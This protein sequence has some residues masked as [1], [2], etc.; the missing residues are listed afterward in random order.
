MSDHQHSGG[1]PASFSNPFSA[2]EEVSALYLILCAGARELRT[3]CQEHEEEYN[4]ALPVP[5]RKIAEL[6]NLKIRERNLS[7]LDV[8]ANS[9]ASIGMLMGKLDYD[10]PDG[11]T[12]H[13][14]EG[15][16]SSRKNYVIAHEL[17]HHWM[18]KI[19]GEPLGPEHCSDTRLSVRYIEMLSDAFS[20][21]LLLPIKALFQEEKQ[22]IESH[23]Q[24]PVNLEEMLA[25]VAQTADV[26]YYYVLTGY[27]YIKAVICCARAS[28][29]KERF[30]ERLENYLNGPFS[31]LRSQV[32]E[33]RREIREIDPIFF[34]QT[35]GAEEEANG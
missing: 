31:S 16:S 25:K 2:F 8:T 20:A 6:E 1:T 30:E 24:R 9:A 19:L 18:K 3:R 22:Y 28:A 7:I 12:I 35:E 13:L 5:V 10:L 21:F 14:E 32:D 15:I 34:A 26:P 27:E 23:P 29:P 11:P 33:V 17:G 4:G